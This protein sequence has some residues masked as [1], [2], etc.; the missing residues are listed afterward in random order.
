MAKFMA[1]S[2]YVY[3]LLKMPTEHGVLSLRGSVQAAYNCETESYAAAEVVDLSLCMKESLADSKK[4]DTKDLEIPTR[5]VGR[6]SAK[7]KDFKEVELVPGDRTK[8]AHFRPNLN[9]K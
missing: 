9:P 4:L 7:A 8:T 6:S 2:H 3:L 5:E 1:I